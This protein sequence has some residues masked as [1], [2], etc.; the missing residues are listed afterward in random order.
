M[1]LPMVNYWRTR[2]IQTSG[3]AC[4]EGRAKIDTGFMILGKMMTVDG[5]V[6]KSG[7]RAAVGRVKRR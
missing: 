3:H 6:K 5:I 2:T 1:R 4:C 7:D